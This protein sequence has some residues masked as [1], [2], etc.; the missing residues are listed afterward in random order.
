MPSPRTP[1]R[2]TPIAAARS[3]V[4]KAFHRT[5]YRGI[6]AILADLPDLRKVIGLQH[7]PHFTTLHKA[8]QRLLRAAPAARLLEA[9][10]QQAIESN[11][12]CKRVS[13]AAL[14]GTGFETRHISA[15]FVKRRK[16]CVPGYETTTYTRFPKAGL[17]CDCRSH[18]IL[19]VV[20]GRGPGPDCAHYCRALQQATSRVRIGTLLADAGYDSE[21][22]H[23][24]AREVCQ[25]RTLIPPT[26][27]RPTS[28]RPASRWRGL[29]AAR[30]NRQKYGQRWQAETVISMIK[31]L[32]QSA[33]HARRYWSQ[34]REIT[35]RAITLNIMILWRRG[36][37]FLQSKPDPLSSSPFFFPFLLSRQNT[38]RSQIGASVF[39][40]QRPSVAPCDFFS[41]SF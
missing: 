7:V 15:Y 5:D 10:I 38:V 14:D 24:F 33:L 35:L 9:T 17:L 29:M 23:L 41:S 34:C 31:R 32:L 39:H 28:K 6:V 30:F 3:L 40:V 4:L 36:R 19:S 11:I 12:L 16:R 1:C 22:A 21:A 26:R 13:L 2:P 25:A 37:G 27:G 20:A 8:E 18:I